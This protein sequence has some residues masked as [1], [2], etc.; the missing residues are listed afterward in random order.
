MGKL[1]C[2]DILAY[3]QIS[4][5]FMEIVRACISGVKR[6]QYL[7]KTPI[8]VPTC[9]SEVYNN[10]FSVV[11]PL[12]PGLPF[13]S[14]YLYPNFFRHLCSAI[15]FFVSSEGTSNVSVKAEETLGAGTGNGHFLPLTLS[16]C[17][18]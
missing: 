13:N 5:C 9:I 14:F 8:K 17:H 2:I 4:V 3:T 15:P 11:P 12:I 16:L 1:F 10:R 18:F 6:M 7:R